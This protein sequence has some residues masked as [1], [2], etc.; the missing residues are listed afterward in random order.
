MTSVF[1]AHTAGQSMQSRKESVQWGLVLLLS[2]EL[3]FYAVCP[4]P[5]A[6]ND[7]QLGCQELGQRQ[8]VDR[9]LVA[10]HWHVGGG[11]MAVLG[12]SN[13]RG[14]VVELLLWP[15]NLQ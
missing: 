7:S 11:R 10:N 14:P 15:L 1:S 2:L 3:K 8:L 9:V 4:A 12:R 6:W 13:L 5:R